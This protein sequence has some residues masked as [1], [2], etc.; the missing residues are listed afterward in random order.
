MS[1]IQLEIQLVAIATAIACAIPGVFLVLR[2]MAF[3]SD[4]ISHTVLLGIVIAYFFTQNLASPW[5][6][7]GAALTGIGTVFLVQILQRT[8]LVREDAAIGLVFPCL[9]SIAVIL[10]SVFFRNVHLDLDAVLVGKIALAPLPAR[11]LDVFGYT[12]GPKIL[13]WM[14]GLA[15]ANALLAYLFFKELQISSFDP[16]FGRA[17]GF[18][19]FW[20]QLGLVSSVSTTAV[21][22]FDAVGSIL[23]VAFMTVPPATAYLLTDRLWKMIFLAV[24]IATLCA[25][26][27]YWLAH[28]LD[29]SISG[30]MATAS[31]FFFGSTILF[32]PKKGWITSWRKSRSSRKKV[33]VTLLVIHLVQHENTDREREENHMDSLHKHLKWPEQEII[34]ITS[35]SISRG[36]VILESGILKLTSKGRKYAMDSAQLGEKILG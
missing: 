22:A 21:A 6:I 28:W 32:A 20:I 25:V 10:I 14:I 9:F 16:A 18:A 23:V 30:C 31:G 8:N 24:G 13:V 17:L 33:Q 19:P 2:R 15:L 1:Q 11:R 26:G 29:A 12:L 27:G 4:A 36:F 5:L 34:D 7:G 3:I 35:R